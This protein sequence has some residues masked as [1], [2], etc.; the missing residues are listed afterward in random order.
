MK[1][2][3]IDNLLLKRKSAIQKPLSFSLEAGKGLAIY[4]S[5]GSGK[6][7]LLDTIA[8]V[9]P[10]K[11]GKIEINGV[12]GYVIHYGGFEEHLTCL[13]NL[14]LEARYAK[15]PKE[16]I[17]ERIIFCS[18]RCGIT[19]FLNTKI[20]KLSTGMRVRVMIAASLL[21]RPD[22]LLMDES[23][24]ALDERSVYQ[25]KQLLLE[26]KKNGLSL[27]VVSHRLSD[28]QDICER[29]FLFENNEVIDFE[30][31]KL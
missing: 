30:D 22:I 26:E 19:P 20:R 18:D 8:G 31:F 21:V 23:F 25:I 17:D 7:T 16:K 2:I 28:F 24:N 4:G 6:S 14:Y 10:Y 5:N 13:D 12:L 9:L 27:L 29:I 15:M 3:V 11:G 1:R